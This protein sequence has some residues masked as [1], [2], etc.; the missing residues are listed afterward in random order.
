MQYSLNGFIIFFRRFLS[1]RKAVTPLGGYFGILLV[2]FFSVNLI[3][4]ATSK[5][6]QNEAE[7]H[8]RIGTAHLTKGNLPFALSELNM[9]EKLDPNNPMVQ[10]NLGLVY[11]F[12]ERYE[13]SLKHLD[14]ALKIRPD[15][16]EARNNH[17]RVLIELTRYD[18]AIAELKIVLND[19]TYPEPAK[20]WV[21]MGIA[22]FRKNDFATAKEKFAKA[23][24]INREN[25]LAHTYFGRALLEL[26]QLNQAS[27]ALDNA[28]VICRPNRFEEPHYYSG[29]TYYKLGKTTSAIARMEEVIHLFPTGKFVKRAE[30][31]IKLMR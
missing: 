29:L 6:E 30:S 20:A 17:A 25:C 21:N 13:E 12:N 2:A 15:F 10:N 27:S 24:E 16:T 3:A 23:I 14:R 31:M 4:C 1:R 8:M 28:V 7:L 5:K 11:F 26:Q 18:A 9:A 19:L 22:F